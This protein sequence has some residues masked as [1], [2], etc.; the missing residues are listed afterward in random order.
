MAVISRPPLS[1]FVITGLISVSSSTRSPIT[2]ASPCIGAN[3]TH[4]PSASAGLIATPSSVTCKSERGSPYRWTSPETAA[5]LPSAA[6]TFFQSMSAAL[7]SGGKAI[8]A[9][10]VKS[11]RFRF[12]VLSLVAPKRR[13]IPS[14]NA[15]QPKQHPG[16]ARSRQHRQHADVEA[17]D[18]GRSRN[19]QDQRGNIDAGQNRHVER[20]PERSH[21]PG[22]PK[23]G[24][25]REPDRQIEDHADDGGGN[26][27]QRAGKS[28]VAAQGL[29]ERRAQKDPEEAG[30]EGDPRRQQPAKGSG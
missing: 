15:Q 13:L 25:Q 27:G 8:T 28:L 20:Q 29:D 3:A 9:R 24:V 4:P 10:R 26:G 12:I 14:N 6:S 16:S 2:M 1:N 22:L 7:A 18:G 11:I 30:R 19:G 5:V 21:R 17:E 23:H